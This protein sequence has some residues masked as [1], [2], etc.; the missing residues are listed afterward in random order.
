M[1][2]QTHLDARNEAISSLFSD[3][4]KAQRVFGKR[5]K[6]TLKEGIESMAA[7]VKTHG[8]RA[9]NVFKDIEI[10]KNMP[11]SWAAA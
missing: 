6:T 1:Q 7:W 8:A 9:S 3:H 2:G 5:K 11:P 4:G 10:M